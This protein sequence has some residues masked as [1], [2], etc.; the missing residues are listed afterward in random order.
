MPKPEFEARGRHVH[1]KPLET[2][3]TSVQMG[4]R[5]FTVGEFVVNADKIAATIAKLM[6]EHAEEFA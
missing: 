3:K 2:S 5:V 1:Q 4:F 6:N